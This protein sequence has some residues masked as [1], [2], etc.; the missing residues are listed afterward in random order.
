M[1]IKRARERCDV[2]LY[3]FSVVRTDIGY[4]TV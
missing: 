2:S 3:Y 4:S 1:Q